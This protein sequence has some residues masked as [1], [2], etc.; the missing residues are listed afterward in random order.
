MTIQE[1]GSLGE[2]I[3]AVATVLTI[4]Y[5]AM[6]I[7]QNTQTARLS[8]TAAHSSSMNAMTHLLAQDDAARRV[9]FSGLRD[10]ASLSEE[11]QEKFE[12]LMMLWMG[13]IQ[14]SFY[15]REEGLPDSAWQQISN[16][17]AW[18]MEQPGFAPYWEK[19]SHASSP[20]FL[21]WVEGQAPSLRGARSVDIAAQQSAAADPAQ[22]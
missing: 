3:A 7:R 5:L 1:L 15:M 21:V 18:V 17:F 12:S 2:L 8:A 11:E 14:Q 6:Q 16:S 20:D 22:A 9:Y 10:Y 19:W 4:A 13:G